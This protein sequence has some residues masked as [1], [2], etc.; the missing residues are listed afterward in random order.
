M[1]DVDWLGAVFRWLPV[2]VVLFVSVITIAFVQKWLDRRYKADPGRGRMLRQTVV[3]LLALVTVVAIVL[4]IPMDNAMRSQ[5]FT[6]LGIAVT[7]TLTLSST[8]FIG[9]AMAGFMLRSVRMYKPG[10]F[11]RVNNYFGR[12]SEQGL[13]HT[14]IQTEDRDLTTL[15]NLYLVTNPVTR[16]RPSGTVISAEVSLGYDIARDIIERRLLVAA[17]RA[18]LNSGFVRILSLGDFSVVYRVGGILENVKSLLVVQSQLRGA[19]IDTLHEAKIEIVSPAFMNQRAL[20]PAEKVIPKR[21]VRAISDAAA[22]ADAAIFDK[23]EEAQSRHE[24]EQKLAAQ[25]KEI[26]Q[27]DSLLKETP[28]EDHKRKEDLAAQLLRATSIRDR[29]AEG[30]LKLAT[31]PNDE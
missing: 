20:V 30:V 24:L 14:E 27:L 12:V 13:L 1:S 11:I 19:V 6:L 2:P 26:Q 22:E 10:D 8:T 31:P 3:M 5:L 21:K 9:N 28:K 25:E 18:G 16:V 29:I 15:P 23:A 17:E 7:A 4:M